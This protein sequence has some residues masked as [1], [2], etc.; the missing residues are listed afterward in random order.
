M[1]VH[2]RRSDTLHIKSRMRL[3]SEPEEIRYGASLLAETQMTIEE[4]KAIAVRSL[5]GAQAHSI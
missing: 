1:T 2:N 4:N 5:G 3:R